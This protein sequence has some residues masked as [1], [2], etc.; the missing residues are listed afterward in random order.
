MD[1]SIVKEKYY[2]FRV[3]FGV[4]F[5]GWVHFSFGG[6]VAWEACFCGLI[7]LFSLLSFFFLKM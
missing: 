2:G 7:V 6:L 1:Y 4:Y 3:F 5:F